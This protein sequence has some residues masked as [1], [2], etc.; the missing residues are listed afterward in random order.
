[1]DGDAPQTKTSGGGLARILSWAAGALLVLMLGAAVAAWGG[2]V[3]LNDQFEAPGPAGPDETVQLAR[4]DGLI[5][6][7][8]Q[9]EREGFVDD[10]RLFRILVTIDG[11][12]RALRAGEFAVPEA[13]SMQELYTLFRSGETIQHPVT[14]AEGLTS[15]MIVAIVDASPVLTGDIPAP[16]A[17]GS[18]LPETYLVDRGAARE[19]VI[20]RMA[21]A[22]DA[23]LAEIW[24]TRADDLPFDTQEEA[25]TLASI[26]EKETGIGGERPLVAGVFVNRLR[27]GMRLQSDP[28]IIYG[29]TQGR[30]LGRG[31]RRSELDDADNP[32]NTYQINGLPPTPIA[33]PGEAALRAVLNP[34]Q[35]DYLFFVADGTG[36]H[37]F[38][39]TYAEHNRNVAQWRR[40]E[41]ERAR[42]GG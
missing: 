7:A 8:A 41:R 17:E 13:A 11:G 10:A 2:W 39:E 37:A 14:A 25:I 16:P 4:G 29:L 1:M 20:S 42:S 5:A 40:I 3:W 19:A 18:L 32:Y 35:T 33:N 23:L 6:I 30:S 27:R 34:P 15:A 22:Q 26:V 21:A 12:D 28:T 38:A 9:L 24:P 36:G 31:I